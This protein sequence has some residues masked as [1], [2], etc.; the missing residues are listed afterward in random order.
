M[1]AYGAAR[2]TIRQAIATLRSEGLIDIEHGRG[3]FVRSRPPIQRKA[4]D[5]FARAHRD[6]GKAAYLAEMEQE[7]RRPDVEVLEVGPAPASAR[8]PSDSGSR[9]GSRCWS[10]A[11]ATSRMGSRPSWPQLPSGRWQARYRDAAGRLQ[12]APVTFATKVE[13]TRYLATVEADQTLGTWT[14]PRL[15]RTTF[16]EW[17]ERWQAT[18]TDLRP[19]TRHLYD[20]LLDRF[21]FP[22]FEDMPLGRLDVMAVRTWLAEQRAAEKVSASTT[23]KA[24][25]LLARILGSAVEA[26]YIARNPCTVKGAGVERA[27]EMRHIS[28]AELTQLASKID[29]RYRALVL[30]AGYGGLRWGDLVGLRRFRSTRCTRPWTWPSRSWRSTGRSRPASPRP[31][32]GAASSPFRPPR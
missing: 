12:P 22:A 29:R 21:L 18:T 20:Y 32:P 1:D 5:R 7:G 23:A 24:Y 4:F 9:Q 19:T 27:P 28:A 26:G 31:R 3:A 10:G 13:A 11:A 30:V 6:Q 2:G 16:K 8:S 25:R 17:A 14:D 15:G